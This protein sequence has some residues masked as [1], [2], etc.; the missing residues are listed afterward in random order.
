MKIYILCICFLGITFVLPAYE[1][2]Q[3]KKEQEIKDQVVIEMTDKEIK[4]LLIG[5][6]RSETV[7]GAKGKIKGVQIYIFNKDGSIEIGSKVFVNG[8]E[9]KKAATNLKGKWSLENGE[10]TIKLTQGELSEKDTSKIISISESELTAK[11]SKVGVN[12]TMKKVVE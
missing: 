8:A 10:L 11:N 4:K 9:N 12:F 2:V 6:W 3:G 7:L 1:K 5:Q